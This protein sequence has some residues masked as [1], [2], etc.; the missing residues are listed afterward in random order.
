MKVTW[1]VLF[2]LDEM[3]ALISELNQLEGKKLIWAL[4]LAMLSLIQHKFLEEPCEGVRLPVASCL[5]HIR[6]LTTPRAPYNDDV[7]GSVFKLIVDT[8]QDLDNNVGPTFGKKVDILEVIDITRTY[9]VMVDLEC[10]G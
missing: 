7:M 1:K 2:K 8:F 10:D 6:R 4:R 5:S 9:E 3:N